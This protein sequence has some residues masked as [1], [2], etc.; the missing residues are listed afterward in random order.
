M[1]VGGYEKQL[2]K[3]CLKANGNYGRKGF[4]EIERLLFMIS[5]LL[6]IIALSF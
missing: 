5:A 2:P 3:I 1:F 4:R 6:V